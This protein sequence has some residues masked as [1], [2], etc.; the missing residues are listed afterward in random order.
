M[1]EI[2]TPRRRAGARAVLVEPAADALPFDVVE[3][4][5]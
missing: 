4:K 3:S 2:R 5:L 1:N